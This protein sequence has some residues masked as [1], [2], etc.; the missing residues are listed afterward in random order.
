ML[1]NEPR[2]DRSLQAPQ[3]RRRYSYLRTGFS[4]AVLDME[5][6][7]WLYPLRPSPMTQPYT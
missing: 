2:N 1:R 4:P 6:Q 5:L 3:V 7:G